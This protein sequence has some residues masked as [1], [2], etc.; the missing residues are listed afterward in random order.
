MLH[1]MYL[2]S[3][4]LFRKLTETINQ[5][6]NISG[7]CRRVISIRWIRLSG[8]LR[9]EDITHK[10]QLKGIVKFMKQV[11]HEPPFRDLNE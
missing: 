5:P 10:A 1:K 4:K 8:K 7:N 2:V 6:S 11:L 9:E 3:P